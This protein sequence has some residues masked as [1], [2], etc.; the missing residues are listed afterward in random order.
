MIE[1]F[2]FLHP[3]LLFLL[4]A[5]PLLALWKGRWG[6]PLAVRIPTTLDAEMIGARSGGAE[7]PGLRD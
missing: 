4:L 7:S 5:L 6:A 2:S 3:G 1:N